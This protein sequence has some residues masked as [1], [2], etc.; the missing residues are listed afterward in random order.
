MSDSPESAGTTPK[1]SVHDNHLYKYEFDSRTSTLVLRT[2]FNVEPN[3][4]TDVWF[5]DVWCHHLEGVLGGDIIDRTAEWGLDYELKQ[6]V[7]LFDRLKNQVG[8]PPVDWNKETFHEAVARRNL[9]VWHINSNYGVDGFVIA[10][11]MRMFNRDA[12]AP[13]LTLPLQSVEQYTPSSMRPAFT[14][15]LCLTILCFLVLMASMLMGIFSAAGLCA[16]IWGPSILDTA[17][18]DSPDRSHP[19]YITFLFVMVPGMLIG[20]V[21]GMAGVLVP[22]LL[23]F[24]IHCRDV[25]WFFSPASVA[26]LR[27]LAHGILKIIGTKNVGDKPSPFRSAPPRP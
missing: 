26:S 18:G 10:K 24:G 16:A 21:G 6:F 23:Y 7:D 12:E 22:L 9:R 5:L 27:S 19:A 2:V 13:R 14:T 4:F 25:P 3:E 17:L 20:A 1:L 11:E 8:W 15:R